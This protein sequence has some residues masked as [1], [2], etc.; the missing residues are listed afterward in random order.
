[1]AT[2]P[3]A[4]SGVNG[5][6]ISPLDVLTLAQAAEYL[7]LPEDAVRAEAEA[8]RI[9]GRQISGEWRFL[10]DTIIQWLRTPKKSMARL[11]ELPPLHETPEEHEAFMAGIAA[12]RDEID[13]AT[14]SGKYA[15]E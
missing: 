8:G 3:T 9:T 15:P 1:M 5:A 11:A 12:Y 10:R 13:R 7:Q 14:G 2:E 6:P 4:A